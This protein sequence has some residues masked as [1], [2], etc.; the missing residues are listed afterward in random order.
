MARDL[1]APV[2]A[3]VTSDVVYPILL[4]Q[5]FFDSGTMRLWNGIGEFSYEGNVYSGAGEILRVSEVME[6]SSVEARG[7]TFEMSGIPTS[8]LAI[9]LG[10][11]YS[12]RKVTQ[13]FAVLDADGQLIGTPYLFFSGKMDVMEIQKGAATSIIRISAE[14]DLIRL[15][16]AT[17]RRRTPEDQKQKYSFD[18]F[19]DNVISLQSKTLLWGRS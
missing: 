15:K 4:I 6:T 7:S 2:E 13:H 14:N 10:E 1:T 5:G 19:F 11:D 12:G 17:P 3:A 8:L 18:S 16:R 9:A